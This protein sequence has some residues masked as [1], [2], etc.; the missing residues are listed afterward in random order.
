MDT[1]LLPSEEI[2]IDSLSAD[3]T[4]KI[5]KDRT[6]TSVAVYLRNLN[7]EMVLSFWGKQN[8]GSSINKITIFVRYHPFNLELPRVQRTFQ[9]TTQNSKPPPHVSWIETM[10]SICGR[11]SCVFI[12]NHS[13]AILPTTPSSEGCLSSKLMAVWVPSILAPI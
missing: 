11:S 4:S 2:T 1:F 3:A 10:A 9:L 6:T 13:S 7:V 5:A 12:S 8:Y